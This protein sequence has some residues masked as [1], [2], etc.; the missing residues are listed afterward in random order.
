[1]SPLRL[2]IHAALGLALVA[3]HAL[4]LQAA[5]SFAPHR[6]LY[7]LSLSH[8][9]GSSDVV[10]ANGK[11]EFQ[12]DDI[13]SGWTI[14]QRTR[15]QMVSA[16]GL[17]VDFGWT[18][19]AFESKDG[20]DYRFVIRRFNGDGSSEEVSGSARLEGPGKRGIATFEKPEPR[21]L[22][23]P[24]GTLFPTAHSLLLIEAAQRGALPL[25]K[26]V[27]DGSGDTALFGVNAALTQA[28]PATTPSAFSS[29]LLV[30]KPSWKIDLAFFSMDERQ[31][32]PEQEQV[33][34]LYPQGYADEMIFDY[35]D[36]ALDA[37]LT[38]LDP[39]A[40]R[41]C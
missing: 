33:L 39:L 4:P 19:D 40:D 36:F 17:V 15:V 10:Q 2:A 16:E 34:R 5:S 24:A 29:P 12:W 13:C 7:S 27:F 32:L 8:S 25:W 22:E 38:D 14:A 26:V 11:L 1:M 21:Q 23:L 28:L 35:G 20:R 18:F 9:R 30:G 31:P 41:E 37:R 6:A 3:S